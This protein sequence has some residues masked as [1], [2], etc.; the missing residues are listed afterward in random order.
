MEASSK[1]DDL[2]LFWPRSTRK[3]GNQGSPKGYQ[4]NQAE[5]EETGNHES[6][7]NFTIS[8]ISRKDLDFL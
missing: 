6:L 2:E 7:V 3:K 5:E 4:N 8:I 1:M